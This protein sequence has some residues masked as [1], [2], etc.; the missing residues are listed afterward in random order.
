MSCK[1]GF[2]VLA[3]TVAW[4]RVALA[5]DDS[6]KWAA[7]MLANEAKRDFDAGR[8]EDARHKFQRAYELAK[9]PTLAVWAARALAKHGQLVAASELYRQATRLTP[10][11]LWVG[12]VQQQAQGDAE[13]EL[14]ELQPRIPRLRVRVEGAAANDVEVTI[15]DIKLAGALF[16]IDLPADPGRRR[17]VGKRGG[18]TVEQTI[19]LGEGEH[20]EAVLTLFKAVQVEK[21]LLGEM[22]KPKV[23]K[24]ERLPRLK[25]LVLGKDLYAK[26]ATHPS[27][28]A[29]GVTL[30]PDPKVIF[31]ETTL[32]FGVGVQNRSSSPVAVFFSKSPAYPMKPILSVMI[33]GVDDMGRPQGPEVY[34]GIGMPLHFEQVD[35]PANTELRVVA[36]RNL[37]ELE[38]RGRPSA[39]LH[40][41]MDLEGLPAQGEIDLVL[42]EM[43]SLHLAARKGWLEEVSKLIARGADVNALDRYRNPPLVSAVQG[44]DV[45][46]VTLLLKKG[47][48]ARSRVPGGR[49]R[50][51]ARRGSR[52]RRGR[53]R[54][55]D[56]G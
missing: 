46:V 32:E 54:R 26:H 15:D 44:G 53:G 35:I 6:E 41:A 31:A 4:P 56:E 38:Y 50:G 5:T 25:K 43:R 2:V 22:D 33:L 47:R 17:V 9:V 14:A 10:N 55:A 11:D 19:E 18:E 48:E 37:D 29:R 23:D 7:R 39:K 42:P 34:D 8:F 49:R 52:S 13:K 21:P 20:K 28:I 30:N 1:L 16:G 24:E 12:N 27:P 45:Q 36:I 40:W 51:E 3:L